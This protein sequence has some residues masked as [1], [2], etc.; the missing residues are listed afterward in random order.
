MSSK[1]QLRHG[2]RKIQPD[3]RPDAVMPFSRRPH[4]CPAVSI[5][6]GHQQEGTWAGHMELQAASLVLKAN[7]AIHQ[8]D[9]PTWTIRNFPEGARVLHLSYHDG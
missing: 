1:L 8:A 6:P 4:S 3:T 7:I 5:W 9:Q 2:I